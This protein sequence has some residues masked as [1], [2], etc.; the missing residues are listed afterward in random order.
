MAERESIF[1]T[2][3]QISGGRVS[4][5]DDPGLNEMMLALLLGQAHRCHADKSKVRVNTEGKAKDDGCDAWSPKPATLD[6][7]LGNEETCWQ[8]KAGTAGE[9]AK[10]KGEVLKKIPRET[11]EKG[12]RF[13]VVASGS[14]NGKKGEEDRLARLKEDAREAGIPNDKIEVIGSEGLSIWCNQHPAIAARWANLPDGLWQFDR[15]KAL[16]QHQGAWKPTDEQAKDIEKF[17]SDL[18]P[19]SG[20]I[21]HLH[22]QG[23]AGVGKTRFV[24]EL[25]RSAPWLQGVV[26]IQDASEV[27]RLG[28]LIDT[29][30]GESDVRLTL[31]VD[32][33]QAN[34]LQRLFDSIQHGAGRIRLITIGHCDS[35]DPRIPALR[36]SPLDGKTMRGIVQAWHPGMPPE[37]V[38]FV[39]R[40]SDGYVRLARL[41]ADAIAKNPTT[42]VRALL[43]RGDI[44]GVLEKMLGAPGPDTLAA[45]YVVALLESVGWTAEKEEEGRAI[46]NHLDLNWTKVQMEVERMHVRFGIAPPGGRRRYIS[47]TPLGVYL[48]IEAWKT[49]PNKVKTLPD[50]LPSEE[51]RDAFYR[52]LSRITSSPQ[53]KKWAAAEL[54]LFFS[55]NDFNKKSAARRWV[56]LAPADPA[57]A[58]GAL[59]RGLAKASRAERLQIKGDVR[60]ELVWALIGLAWNTAT[61]RDAVLS[62]ALLADAENE[63]WANNASH[64]FEAR[65][66]I[67]LGGTAVPYKDRLVILE[68][69]LKYEGETYAQ[70]AAKALLGA[71]NDHASRMNTEPISPFIPEKEWAP[72][73]GREYFDCVELAVDRLSRLA[74]EDGRLKSE[75]LIEGAK[76]IV[77]ILRNQWLRKAGMKYLETVRRRFPEQ[78]EELRRCTSA[79]II[80]ERKHPS[81]MPKED[82]AEIERFH[83]TFVDRSDAGQLRQLVGDPAWAREE[84]PALGELAHKLVQNPKSLGSEW[85]W[86]TSGDATHAWHLGQVLA[87]EDSNDVV[88]GEMVEL[89]GRGGDLRV[90]VGYLA[91]RSKDRGLE[92]LE[93]WMEKY[94]KSHPEDLALLLEVTWRCDGTAKMVSRIADFISA[95]DVPDLVLAQLSFGR[96][97][98]QL[99]VE[100]LTPLLEALERKPAYRSTG[101]AVLQHRLQSFPAELERWMPLARAFLAHGELMREG[102]MTSYYW[103]EIASQLVPKYPREIAN[104]ILAEHGKEEGKSQ[105]FLEHSK[106]SNVLLRCVDADPD[107]CWEEFHPYLENPKTAF[108][109]TVGFPFGVL[110]RMPREKVW[111]WIDQEPDLRSALVAR[112]IA[113]DFS[114]DDSMA[115]QLIAKYGEREAVAGSF[116]SSYVSGSWWGP[117]SEHWNQLATKLENRAKATNLPGLRKWAEAS[118]RY[119]R[120][121]A[122]RD[123]QHED[124]R[125]IGNSP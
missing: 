73:D 51:A 49:F 125:N 20:N 68:E 82:L 15:W 83:E 39:V 89:P 94:Q 43:E 88:L 85:S 42:D 54:G 74:K 3:L 38:D 76:K 59:H 44:K 117:A 37:H 104:T 24:M 46:A 16:D 65:F 72:K 26:Y 35:P 7:W 12:G 40:F 107:G 13:I 98:E 87:D 60:R 18:D 66:M 36:V 114:S 118:A 116:Q 34:Q 10:L 14:V 67:H 120:Q 23:N 103:E 61:F 90:I 99:S 45:L 115:A 19:E 70:L 123:K 27:Q 52:R 92:W 63:K 11:L 113:K 109:T 64:E 58:A 30:V 121:M 119:I 105:W 110:E 86:L 21:W 33:V 32:E 41:T 91:K 108:L 122:E 50:A 55:L 6:R 75:F 95:R 93:G 47:P 8:L 80:S 9:P 28:Q 22:V 77:W 5:L 78:R 53:A 4:A 1:R 17:R 71:V 69:I 2:A 112:I 96:W 97:Y 31:V 62:L 100:A 56:A 25:C 57:L 48:A 124:E 84:L 106:I 111:K 101:I 29:V 79:V 81:E 102:D